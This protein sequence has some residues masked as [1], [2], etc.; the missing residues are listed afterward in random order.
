MLRCGFLI[1]FQMGGG[2]VDCLFLRFVAVVTY[3]FLQL[4]S[5]PVRFARPWL[6]MLIGRL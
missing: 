5:L 3:C 6:L 4:L 1:L 2:C